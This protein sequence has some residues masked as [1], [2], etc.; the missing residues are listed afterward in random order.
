M[1]IDIKPNIRTANET[2]KVIIEV[3]EI[4]ALYNVLTSD[5]NPFSVMFD[6]KSLAEFVPSRTVSE[7]L[8]N[9]E[10]GINR[11]LNLYKNSI[12]QNI[13]PYWTR[14]AKT[15]VHYPQYA[16]TPELEYRW[17]GKYHDEPV[18]MTKEQIKFFQKEVERLEKIKG[19]LT[20]EK[21]VVG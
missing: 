1:K 2:E 15:M 16:G 8:K 18:Q 4:P 20:F 12:K 7:M 19:P 17:N 10:E 3:R 9:W 5:G 13:H 14:T 11:Q 6:D 21:V